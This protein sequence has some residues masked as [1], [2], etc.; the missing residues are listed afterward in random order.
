MILKPLILGTILLATVSTILISGEPSLDQLPKGYVD[1]EALPNS[2]EI[3]PEAPLPGSVRQKMDDAIAA[4]A[5]KL[6][7]TARFE[8][9]AKDADLFFPQ[10]PNNFACALGAVISE[11]K[12]PRLYHLMLRALVDGGLS[13]YKAKIKYNRM[14]PFTINNAPICTPEDEKILRHDGSYP[15]GHTALGWTWAL[16][17]A[18]LAPDKADAILARGLAYGESRI[19]CNVH[20]NSDVVAGRIMGSATVARMH[21]SPEFIADMKAAKK[22]LAT[23]PAPKSQTCQEEA[24]A[25]DFKLY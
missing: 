9:A 8:L 23:A 2:I 6:N 4:A 20:W 16:I 22:E 25:L 3:V 19:I 12:T 18:E 5:V 7:K 1:K 15:S 17:L 13:T 11:E 21:N 10:A 24:A 14:R